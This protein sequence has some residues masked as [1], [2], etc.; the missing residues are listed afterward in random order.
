M[1]RIVLRHCLISYL[2]GTVIL[3]TTVSLIAG[4]SA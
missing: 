2:F 3:A 4:L 1:R